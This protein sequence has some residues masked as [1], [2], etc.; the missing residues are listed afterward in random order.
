MARESGTKAL[1]DAGIDYRELN[2][3]TSATSTENRRRV[4]RALYELGMTGIPIVN[5]QQ[6]LLD[7]IHGARRAG[8]PR[9][10]GRWRWASRRCSPGAGRW[11]RDDRESP[12]GRHVKALA[13]IDEFGSGG[14]VD[15]QGPA[16]RDT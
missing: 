16:G 6:Q 11:R 12:L 15:V 8:H 14:A 3:A 1:R 5:D 7:R 4:S 9:R 13:E 2:R 10:T